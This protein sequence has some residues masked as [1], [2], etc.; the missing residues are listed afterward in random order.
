MKRLLAEHPSLA[1]ARIAG[2]K[3]GSRTP[4]HVATDWPGYF[5]NGPAVVAALVEEAKPGVRS[6]PLPD[7]LAVAVVQEERT[8]ELDPGRRTIEPPIGGDLLVGEEFDRH[9][10]Q[11]GW[12]VRSVTR[13]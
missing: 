5:P 11:N 2:A 3:G 7:Q 12:A 10:P 13:R 4:L 9:A 8:L 1:T 6:T